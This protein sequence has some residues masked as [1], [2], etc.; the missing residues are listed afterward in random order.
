MLLSKRICPSELPIDK[1]QT[2]NMQNREQKTL[3]INNVKNDL[4]HWNKTQDKQINEG[5]HIYSRTA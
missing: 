2:Q 1:E 3:E 4:F 5:L